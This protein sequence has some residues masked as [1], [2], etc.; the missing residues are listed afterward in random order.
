MRLEEAIRAG[1]SGG[2]ELWV[3]EEHTAPSIGS[4]KVHVLATPVMIN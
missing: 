4:G 1:M 2:A 3:G